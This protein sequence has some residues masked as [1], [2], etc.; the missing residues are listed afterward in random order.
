MKIEFKQVLL[1]A[2]TP[3]LIAGFFSIAPKLYEVISEPKAVLRYTLVAGPQIAIDGVQEQ[4]I[5]VR[6]SN[7]GRKTLTA[8]Q[9]ELSVPGGSLAAASIENNSGLT[10]ESKRSDDKIVVAIPKALE[11]EAFSIAALL[12]TSKQ[13]IA[14]KFLVRSEE[15][16]GKADEPATSPLKD[17]RTTLFSALGA[18]VSVLTMALAALLKLKTTVMSS[19]RNAILYI[20]LSTKVDTLFQAVRAEGAEVT[21]MDFADMLLALGKSSDE[22]ARRASVAGLQCLL[23]IKDVADAS[24]AIAKRNLEILLGKPIESGPHDPEISA[25]D[26]LRFRD[27]V[28]LI[29][30]RQSST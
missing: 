9:A 4:V 30:A 25:R 16:L 24:K 19:K 5:S 11:G 12:K 21:Y 22:S 2:I 29:F 7:A 13:G 3:A 27:H 20:A 10:I 23:E 8:I 15:V 17:I 28:D 1:Y 26:A 6:V 14:P 18:A